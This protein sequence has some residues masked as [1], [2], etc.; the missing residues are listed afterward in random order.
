MDSLP[1]HPTL[2]A[3]RFVQSIGSVMNPTS[4]DEI[5]ECQT[6]DNY[7]LAHEV[8]DII[9]FMKI[10]VEGAELAL[11]QGAEK[12][13]AR[14]ANITILL[15]CTQNR[16]QVRD[17]LARHGFQCFVWDCARQALRSVVF[18]DVVIINNII[19]RRQP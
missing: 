4:T 11:L 1:P 18:D 17:F 3:H 10:D 16:E 8:V 15:E 7:F 6:L 5:V 19:L 13:L 14:S 12:T 9:D 2:D